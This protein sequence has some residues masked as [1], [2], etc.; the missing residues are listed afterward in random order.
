M[1]HPFVS[2]GFTPLIVVLYVT[3]VMEV[4]AE[5]INPYWRQYLDVWDE[6]TSTIV[7]M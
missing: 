2:K 3:G 4:L 6:G 1:Q 5:R 7:L